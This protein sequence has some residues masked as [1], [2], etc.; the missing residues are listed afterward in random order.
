MKPTDTSSGLAQCLVTELLDYDP[1]TGALTWKI[2]RAG[3]VK[4]GQRAGCINKRDGY[5]E[6]WIGE[7][8]YKAARVIHLWMTGEWPEFTVD[9]INLNRADDRWEN[10]R[11]ATQAQNCANRGLKKNNTSGMKGASQT[12]SGRWL[13]TIKIDRVSRCLGTFDTREEAA[14]AYAKALT[15]VY[16]EFARTSEGE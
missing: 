11:A 4:V 3:N 12:Q 15:E 7:R 1:A 8:S 9:H 2:A 13:S 16:G 6:I 14:G 10:L 5:R